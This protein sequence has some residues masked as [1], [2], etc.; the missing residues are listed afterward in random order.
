MLYLRKNVICN[1]LLKKKRV[2]YS[3]D[4]KNLIQSIYINSRKTN[5][6]MRTTMNMTLNHQNYL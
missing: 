1:M 6:S 5:N 4:E 2:K 3:P